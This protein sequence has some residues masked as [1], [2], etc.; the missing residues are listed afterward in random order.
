MLAGYTQDLE[1]DAPLSQFRSATMSF[2]EADGL[3]S[4]T[5][6]TGSWGGAISNL[7]EYTAFGNLASSSGSTVNPL[8]YTGRDYDPETNLRY[9]R[10]RYYD[11]SIGRFTRELAV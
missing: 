5:S 3:G 7:Y 9:Y 2:Y 1:I 8:Q 4:I 11:P 10:A 6:L